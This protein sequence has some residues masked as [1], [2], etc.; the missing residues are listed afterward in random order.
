MRD[1]GDDFDIQNKDSLGYF[2]LGLRRDGAW[3][4]PAG[5]AADGCCDAADRGW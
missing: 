4:F 2:L 5:G 3:S 1:L